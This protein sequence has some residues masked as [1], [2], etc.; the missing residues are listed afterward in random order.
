[1]SANIMK[2]SFCDDKIREASSTTVVYNK[3]HMDLDV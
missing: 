2:G 3:V 1:M